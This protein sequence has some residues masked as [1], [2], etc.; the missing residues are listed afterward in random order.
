M[1]NNKSRMTEDYPSD[2]RIRV[3][4]ISRT[5][6][7]KEVTKQCGNEGRHGD[8]NK[9]GQTTLRFLRTAISFIPDAIDAGADLTNA[10]FIFAQP[11][12]EFV[13]EAGGGDWEFYFSEDEK[14]EIQGCCVRKG[15]TPSLRSS[16][17]NGYET[18]I[19]WLD[20]AKTTLASAK[21]GTTGVF[22]SKQEHNELSTTLICK[23][24][25]EMLYSQLSL[26]RTPSGP[27]YSVCLR[28]VSDLEGI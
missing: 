22:A 9:T 20:Y 19:A 28:E 26:K 16:F 2:R 23:N 1:G 3:N 21:T 27:A 14:D 13:I 6:L 10:A 24:T 7:G 5:I 18:S 25:K 8:L 11:G 15:K 17:W 12:R 4:K